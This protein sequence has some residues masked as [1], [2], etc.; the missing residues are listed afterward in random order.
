MKFYGQPNMLVR[1]RRKKKLTGEIESKAIFRFDQNGEYITNDEDLIKRL[2]PR[3]KHD[4]N[5]DKKVCKQC[6]QPFENTGALLAH[7]RLQHPKEAV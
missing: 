6:G 1:Q 7:Y 4:D 5:E 2:T 3:F